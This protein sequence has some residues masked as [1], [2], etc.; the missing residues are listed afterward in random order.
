MKCWGTEEKDTEMTE[1]GW[2]DLKELE[3]KLMNYLDRIAD[4]LYQEPPRCVLTGGIIPGY[5]RKAGRE[6]DK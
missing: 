2:A 4:G 6:T 1:Q 5:V 3:D